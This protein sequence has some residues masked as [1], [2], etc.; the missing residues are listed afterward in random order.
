MRAL[1]QAICE[2]ALFGAE[3]R[4]VPHFNQDR[5]NKY[6]SLIHDF[7]ET[8]QSREASCLFGIQ[9]LIRR[10]EHPQGNNKLIKL[11]IS[12]SHNVRHQYIYSW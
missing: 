5:M 2:H 9:Q 6:A 4:D 8:K 11:D 3:G 10:L 7:G 1:I 12:K